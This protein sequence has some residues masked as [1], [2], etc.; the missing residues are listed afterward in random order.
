MS[1]NLS[2]NS[3]ITGGSPSQNRSGGKT[4]AYGRVVD[5]ILDE[6]HPEYLKKGGGVSINGVF[7]KPITSTASE[8]SK[9]DLPFAYQQQSHFKTVPL[10]GEIVQVEPLPIPSDTDF[11]GKTRKYYVKILN[12]WNNANNNFY[13]H[14][15]KFRNRFF[16][17]R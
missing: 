1:F 7:Y 4:I 2:L 9:T 3:T 12:L 11:L 13:P 17:R 8:E 15:Q 5:V 10:I 6:N 16:S 14:C